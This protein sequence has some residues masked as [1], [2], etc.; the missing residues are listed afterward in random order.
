MTVSAVR[1]LFSKVL[2]VSLLVVLFENG[3]GY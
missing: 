3:D 1:C 2:N